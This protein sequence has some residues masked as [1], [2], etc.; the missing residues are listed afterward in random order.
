MVKRLTKLCISMIFWLAETAVKSLLR[1]AHIKLPA[2]CVVL[3][4]H[5]IKPDQRD[6]FD[7]QMN[8]LIKTA[9]PISVDERAVITPRA[10]YAAVT[11]DDGFHESILSAVPYLVRRNIP[12]TIFV[13]TGC[14][15]F[16]APWLNDDRQSHHH[17]GY[18]MNA[19]QIKKLAENRIVSFGSHCI[20]HSDLLSLSEQEAKNE[21]FRSKLQLEKILGTPVRTLSFPHGAFNP[22]HVEFAKAAGYERVFSISPSLAFR[23][24]DEYVTGRVRVDPMDWD[25][26]FWL[27]LSGAYRWLSL[28]SWLKRKAAQICGYSFLLFKRAKV[29]AE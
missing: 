15:G 18:V 3:Y 23:R 6:R 8:C 17:G 24:P 19:E 11:F 9:Q 4:Y 2:S 16:N 10:R 5:V 1:T 29:Q 13:P 28:A 25:I 22:R 20:T 12:V 21:I 14:M 27:K 7:S 26:E